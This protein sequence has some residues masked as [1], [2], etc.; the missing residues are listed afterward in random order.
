MMRIENSM[1]LGRKGAETRSSRGQEGFGFGKGPRG[2]ADVESFGE[3]LAV[4]LCFC[5]VFPRADLSVSC[6]D[7]GRKGRL[8]SCKKGFNV[9]RSSKSDSVSF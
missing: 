4:S 5:F 2:L 9:K 6:E 1:E 8:R 3:K 7:R